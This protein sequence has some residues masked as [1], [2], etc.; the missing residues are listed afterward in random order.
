[1]LNQMKKQA[2]LWCLL[3][4][5]I[6]FGQ[7][8][9]PSESWTQAVPLTAVM[10]AGGV[11][12]LSGLHWNPVTNRLYLVQ[13]SGY[14]RV[15]QWNTA[16]NTFSQLAFKNLPGGPEGITQVDYSANEFYVIAENAFEIRKYTT[17]ANLSSVTLAKHWNLLNAPSPMTDTGNTGPEGIVFVPDAA[18]AAAGFVSQQTG[19]PYTSVKGMG[20]L[21]F[22]A[23][24]D[25]GYIWVF[26]INPGVNN[27]FAY[28]GK[29]KSSQAESCDLSFDRTTGLLYILHNISGNN[30]LEVSD[31]SSTIVNGERK[32]TDT[33]E[34]FIPNTP[35]S[36]D[37]V[38]G[39]AL[40]PKCPN[41]GTV[42]AWLCR[43]TENSDSNA[44]Q[45]DALRWFNPFTS[46]GDCLPL[47]TLSP[48]VSSFEIAPNPVGDNLSISFPD[49]KL[50][51]LEIINILGQTVLY[52][53]VIA[54][55]NDADVS[56]LPNG[57][58]TT[59]VTSEGE[60]SRRKFVKK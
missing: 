48:E 25:G 15:L 43:D 52:K 11:Q 38:E 35:G 6:T 37:N 50:R 36:N 10:D 34:Y 26:D 57:V 51:K 49:E 42:S 59:Q 30:R 1:M 2:A 3:F 46:P 12:D 8:A 27:D 16:G 14:L 5:N 53:M 13:G 47:G 17:S 20:G 33:N 40:T 56:A 24:Q 18:L 22:I 45:Q 39:F 23:H 32:L 31:L 58:Y 29:Y 4:V 7:S 28:V 21:V 44:V 19:S 9:W 55:H 54:R 60:I 41:S